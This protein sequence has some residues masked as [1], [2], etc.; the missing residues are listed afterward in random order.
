MNCNNCGDPLPK[1][2]TVCPK[3][4]TI[5]TSASTASTTDDSVRV[6]TGEKQ[7]VVRPWVRYWART[8]DIYLF[9]V[10]GGIVLGM[11]APEA[12]I[13]INPFLL[14]LIFIFAWIFVES[15][16][17]S[18]IHTTP[19]KWLLKTTLTKPTGP[20]ISFSVA[21]E[22]SF[23]VWWRGLGTGFPIAS[24]IT[25]ALAYSRLTERRVTSWDQELGYEVSHATIGSLRVM[26]AIFFFLAM[27][28][29]QFMGTFRP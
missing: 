16:L 29:L 10:V 1:G 9:S 26:G 24:L 4:G 25:C 13:R 27:G 23:T 12:A 15:F 21:M 18:T 20:P 22:R 6:M 17:L 8:F 28:I 19:G 7:H 3:C 11:L 14:S 5:T 2:T